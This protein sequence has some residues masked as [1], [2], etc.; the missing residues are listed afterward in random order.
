MN[1][2]HK[3]QHPFS[4]YN[5]A[6]AF[7]WMYYCSGDGKIGRWIYNS[8]DGVTPFITFHNGVQLR[9]TFMRHDLRQ[10]NY[11]PV[12]GDWIW[13]SYTEEEARDLIH[14]RIESMKKHG[15]TPEPGFLEQEVKEMLDR[16]E[17]MLEQVK[18]EV[19]VEG[20]NLKEKYG[21]PDLNLDDHKLVAIT[22]PS[23]SGKTTMLRHLGNITGAKIYRADD[24]QLKHAL[25]DN[26][27]MTYGQEVLLIDEHRA[28][29]ENISFDTISRYH[30][31]TDIPVVVATQ[32]TDI[33]K[34]FYELKMKEVPNE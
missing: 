30:S 18:R 21:L 7:C 15:M 11:K 14:R 8:R 34:P 1:K 27:V 16:G 24:V 31:N 13:R 3:P 4:T 6:E 20:E 5:H 28:D 17:P 25:Q 29:F 19:T 26:N 22:G 12:P 9:H 23:G 32:A 2:L 10:P 33:P